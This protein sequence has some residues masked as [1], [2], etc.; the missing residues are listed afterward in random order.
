MQQLAFTSE[1]ATHS[2][3]G[4]VNRWPSRLSALPL[5]ALDLSL[6]LLGQLTATGHVQV[7]DVLEVS[8]DDLAK[9]AGISRVAAAEVLDA[10]RQIA[11]GAIDPTAAAAQSIDEELSELFSRTRI[12]DKERAR[13]ILEKHAGLNG[14]ATTLEAIGAEL[15]VTRER[16]RQ[17]RSQTD[18]EISWVLGWFDPRSRATVRALLKSRGGAVPVA[19]VVR[20]LHR[21]IPAEHLDPQAYL[22]WIIQAGGDPA[23]TLLLSDVVVGPPLGRVM[24]AGLI[25]ATQSL[26]GDEMLVSAD[27][28]AARMID[29]TGPALEPYA[30][31]YA[32]VVLPRLGHQIL[33]GQFSVKAW[34]RADWAEYVLR[35]DGGPL[36]YS[37]IAARAHE[38]AGLTF[39]GVSFNSVLNSDERFVRVGAGDFVLASTGIQPYGRFDEVIERYLKEADAPVHEEQIARDLL[40]AYTVT[41]NTL[42]AM[43]RFEPG[44]FEHLGGGYWGLT[45]THYRPD[46]T[47]ERLA[48]T[49]LTV[50]KQ[51][52]PV[53]QIRKWIL[54]HTRGACCPDETAIELAVYLS[55]QIRRFGTS[56][57]VRFHLQAR[58]PRSHG[59][60]E[61]AKEPCGTD[62]DPMSR[63]LEIA[64]FI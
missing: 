39:S 55:A 27:A 62:Q 36:H 31:E 59:R 45:G 53:S 25:E 3:G 11:D 34:S 43:L 12:R 44:R 21:V 48:V 8:S 42:T 50:N 19:E 41:R 37:A 56:A 57:P 29:I 46:P 15:G 60:G 24:F 51:P 63:L 64:D 33:S 17:L 10:V 23:V 5:R 49:C 22:T 30:T 26:L 9:R 61:T 14:S 40:R 13:I 2:S 4:S 6:R 20:E 1:D 18:E 52:L 47:L 58:S 54:E 38:L 28:A 16:V 32:A 35:L 7:Q